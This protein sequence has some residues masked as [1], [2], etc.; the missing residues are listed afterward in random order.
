MKGTL[1]N[2]IFSLLL[3]DPFQIF[4]F[5]YLLVKQITLTQEL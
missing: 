5:E 2:L 3:P 1:K 4:N